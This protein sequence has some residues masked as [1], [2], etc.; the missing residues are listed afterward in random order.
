[1]TKKTGT[2]FRIPVICPGNIASHFQP[3]RRL[4]PP[5]VIYMSLEL[6][7][8]SP[9]WRGREV[10]VLGYVLHNRAAMDVGPSVDQSI[11]LPNPIVSMN[12]IIRIERDPTQN[13]QT[14]V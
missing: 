6:R 2:L 4:E 9:L 13:Q 11:R 8:N 5:Y 3:R 10:I 12:I 14:P 1:M 7:G